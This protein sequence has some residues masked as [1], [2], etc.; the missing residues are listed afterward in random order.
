ME[1][2]VY[3]DTHVIVWLYAGREDL[4]SGRAR[5][6]VQQ[7]QLVFS[8]IVRLELQYLLETDRITKK[9][10][11][12]LATL[13][14]E[15]ALRPCHSS[16]ITVINQ[17]LGLKWTRDPFDRIITAQASANHALLLTKDRTIR[18]HYSKAFWD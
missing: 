7:S 2:L 4:L 1:T 14:A 9:P 8:P 12:I 15:I 5:K 16:F 6:T 10:D 17:A 3:L 13:G 11:Q 18:K